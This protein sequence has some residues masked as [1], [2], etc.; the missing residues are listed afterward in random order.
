M[1][2]LRSREYLHIVTTTSEKLMRIHIAY[3]YVPMLEIAAI[4]VTYGRHRFWRVCRQ[5]GFWQTEKSCVS[6]T[7]SLACA[8]KKI[9]VV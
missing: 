9:Q 7:L 5:T 1:D 4:S 3:E 8:R 6:L 2:R